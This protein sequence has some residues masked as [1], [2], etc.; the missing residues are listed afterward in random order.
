MISDDWA[1][2]I[3]A[4]LVVALLGFFRERREAQGAKARAEAT[5]KARARAEQKAAAALTETKFCLNCGKAI[6][7]IC[8]FC[9][10]CGHTRQ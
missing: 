1:K 2:A 8:K 4:A 5:A 9:P 10:Q 6:S 7:K 3:A